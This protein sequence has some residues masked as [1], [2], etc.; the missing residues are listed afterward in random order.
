MGVFIIVRSAAIGDFLL[1]INA[2]T[3]IAAIFVGFCGRAFTGAT[4]TT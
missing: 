2:C 4:A 3:T 1:F